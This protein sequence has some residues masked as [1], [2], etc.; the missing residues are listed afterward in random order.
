MLLFGLHYR[1]YGRVETGNEKA[2]EV[3]ES[4]EYKIHIYLLEWKEVNPTDAVKQIE[5]RLVRS[6]IK[7]DITTEDQKYEICSA[8]CTD[9]DS[10]ENEVKVKLLKNF[11]NVRRIEPRYSTEDAFEISFG[12]ISSST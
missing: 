3:Q 10:S 2:P 11:S 8:D 7:N 6:F 4:S 5:R 1:K 9:T 12:G